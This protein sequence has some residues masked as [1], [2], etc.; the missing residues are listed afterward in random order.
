MDTITFQALYEA[1]A[2][3]VH[4]FARYLCGRDDAAADVTS[5]S[6]ALSWSSCMR[7]MFENPDAV[8]RGARPLEELLWDF[9]KTP[10]AC[11]VEPERKVVLAGDRLPLTLKNFTDEK[12][13]RSRDFN[14]ILLKA[15]VG[16]LLGG[17]AHKTGPATRVFPLGTGTVE[18]TYQAPATPGKSQDLVVISNSCEILDRGKVPFADTAPRDTIAEHSIDI[19]YPRQAIL[20]A[21]SRAQH[22]HGR[23]EQTL[24]VLATVRLDLGQAEGGVIAPT[25]VMDRGR[26][27]SAVAIRS[28]SIASFTAHATQKSSSGADEWA[29]SAPRFSRPP[30]GGNPIV[31]LR[32]PKASLVQHVIITP[33]AIEFEWDHEG[34][35]FGNLLAFG[36]VEPEPAAGTS[37]A[38]ARDQAV[39]RGD[40]SRHLGG[41]GSGQRTDAS[42]S[43][44]YRW[45]W[46]VA[47]R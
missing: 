25:A 24:D 35:P 10:V 37:L 20:Y 21:R 8:M 3:D 14:R 33:V 5:E 23:L 7:R 45:T 28:A 1:H 39:T 22:Q 15:R 2:R 47:L 32:D 11:E 18:V 38:W 46:D 42:G 29:G 17:V 34:A 13:R 36:P 9:E 27:I 16:T 30:E 19:L 44:T 31:L 4:R 40:G 41:S 6:G 12:G 26:L 43:E